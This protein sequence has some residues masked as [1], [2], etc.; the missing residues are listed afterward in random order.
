MFPFLY[1]TTYTLPDI[2]RLGYYFGKKTIKLNY[3]FLSPLSKLINIQHTRISPV[4]NL[5]AGIVL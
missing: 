2:V 4:K 1:M 5:P 3:I